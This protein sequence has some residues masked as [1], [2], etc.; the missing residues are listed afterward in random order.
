MP[1]RRSLQNYRRALA[2]RLQSLSVVTTTAEGSTSALIASALAGGLENNRY[3]Q[4][5]VL[6]VDGPNAGVLRRVGNQALNTSTGQLSVSVPWG[7]VMPA[8][9]EIEIH[10]LL[11]PDDHDGWTGLRSI[12]NQA[13]SECWT[14]QRLPLTGVADQGTY[15]LSA[16]GDWLEPDAI[17]ELFGEVQAGAL[18]ATPHGGFGPYRDAN[19]L[20]LDIAP[21]LEAG[22]TAKLAVFRPLDTY[23]KVAGTWGDS[24][25][26]LVNDTD[27]A[28]INPEALTEVALAVAYEHL[29]NIPEIGSRWEKKATDQRVRVNLLKLHHLPQQQ[30]RPS[31]GLGYGYYDP[32][33]YWTH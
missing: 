14:F 9:T 18:Y 5:W 13:L 19:T 3:A 16:Y 6:P 22:D 20:N 33:D 17:H 28:L 21:T 10:R 26:G 31:F 11:P 29:A 27:E 8:A 32:K 30:R 12:L 2:R 25:V 4:A 24:T 23:I 15:D 7:T 1:A